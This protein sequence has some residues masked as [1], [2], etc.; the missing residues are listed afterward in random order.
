MKRA[1]GVLV[2]GGVVLAGLLVLAGNASSDRGVSPA[3]ALEQLA[4]GRSSASELHGTT[5]RGKDLLRSLTAF[6]GD[7]PR[8]I[9]PPRW[10][11]MRVG[12]EV[13]VDGRPLRAIPYRGQI[14]LPVTQLG[15]EYQIRIWNHGPRRIA[16]IV[17]VDGLSVINGRPAAENGPGYLVG[18]RSSIVIHGWRRDL[19]TVAAFSFQEREKSYARRRGYPENVGVIGLIAIE[20][21]VRHPRPFPEYKKARG[22]PLDKNG[23]RQ[24]GSTGTGF[25]R[26]INSPAFYVPFVRSANKRM[27]VYYYDT[28]EAL[29]LAGVPVDDGLPRPFP[30]DPDFAPPPRRYPSASRP[31]PSAS[32]TQ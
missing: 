18:P 5:P 30:K 13:L 21:Q 29:R 4:A 31:H 15:T 20:E 17:S 28:V 32:S 24:V 12:M 10:D 11:G 7:R 23:G 1:H 8:P 25:G 22:T 27:I 9:I 3:L 2:L 19:Q 16:A 14:Y 6:P 26:D